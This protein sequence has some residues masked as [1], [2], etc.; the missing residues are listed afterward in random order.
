[1]GRVGEKYIVT[2]MDHG[3]GLS[4]SIVRADGYIVIPKGSESFSQGTELTVHMW[5]N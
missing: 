4:M 1:M 2:P 5:R 3:A